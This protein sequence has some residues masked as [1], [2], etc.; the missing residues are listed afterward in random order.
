MDTASQRRR[1]D[2]IGDL[3]IKCTAPRHMTMYLVFCTCKCV[4]NSADSSISLPLLFS[5]CDIHRGRLSNAQE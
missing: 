2:L 1:T 5:L 4:V 3:T